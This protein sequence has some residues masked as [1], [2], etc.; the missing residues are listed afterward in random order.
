MIEQGSVH[1][2]GVDRKHDTT[3]HFDEICFELFNIVQVLGIGRELI[4]GSKGQIRNVNDLVDKVVC[5]ILHG[6]HKV[7]NTTDDTELD[8][9]V[10]V[11]LDVDHELLHDFG[12]VVEET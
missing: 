3:V 8:L 4:N 6:K 1:F 9:S 10:E 11:L 12:S 5:V 2:V 7:A